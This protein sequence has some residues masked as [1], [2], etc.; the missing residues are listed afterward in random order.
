MRDKN[1]FL[2]SYSWTNVSELAYIQLSCS[3]KDATTCY[4]VSAD[5]QGNLKPKTWLKQLK[6]IPTDVLKT[7]CFLFLIRGRL[8][9]MK[10]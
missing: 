9:G 8:F 2:L 1:A 6:Q 4:Q 5:N 7:K 3:D 10:R